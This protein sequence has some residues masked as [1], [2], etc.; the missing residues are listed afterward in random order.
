MEPRWNKATPDAILEGNK[1]KSNAS[2][3][4][5]GTGSQASSLHFRSKDKNVLDIPSYRSGD[6]TQNGSMSVI[7]IYRQLCNSVL[8]AQYMARAIT[9]NDPNPK[10]ANATGAHTGPFPTS[11]R[12]SASAAEKNP[13]LQDATANEYFAAPS[14]RLLA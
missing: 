13:N 14:G 11:E 12:T 5:P 2:I 4:G 10:E 1:A 9:H 8:P 7:A 6:Y 3:W